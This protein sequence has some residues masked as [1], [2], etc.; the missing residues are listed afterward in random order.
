[1]VKGHKLRIEFFDKDTLTKDD[2]LGFICKPIDGIPQGE[3]LNETLELS[4][5]EIKSSTTTEIRGK[6]TFQFQILPITQGMYKSI[7]LKF[8]LRP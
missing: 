2:P 6:A 4:L 8:Y 7:F 1:M 3:A 5:N